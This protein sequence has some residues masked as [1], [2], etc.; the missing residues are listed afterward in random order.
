MKGNASKL[1][2]F[3]EFLTDVRAGELFRNGARVR[4][5]RKPFEVL[6]ALLDRAGQ[7]VSRETLYSELWPQG[8]PDPRR[9]LDTAVKKLRLALGDSAAWIETIARSGYRLHPGAGVVVVSEHPYA[10][11]RRRAPWIRAAGT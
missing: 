8:A 9:S 7:V 1:I 5:Q 3:G 10:L 2:L 4:L 6:V 11:R